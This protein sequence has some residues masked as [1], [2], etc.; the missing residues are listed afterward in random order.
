VI[1]LARCSTPGRQL[2][3]ALA[4]ATLTLLAAGPGAQAADQPD[5]AVDGAANARFAWQAPVGANQVMFERGL[6]GSVLGDTQFL[7]FANQSAQLPK[8]AVAPDGTA[9]FVWERRDS[10][11]AA[12]QARRRFPDGSLGPVHVLAGSNVV[13]GGG[14]RVAVDPAGNATFTW[15][16]INADGDRI[17]QTRRLEANGTLTATQ[18][19]SATGQDASLPGLAAAPGGDVVFVWQR[20]N[21][22]NSIAQTRRR[23]A[24][25][26]FSAVQ[27]LSA[28]GQNAS[29]SRV[30]VDDDGDATFAWLRSDGTNDIVQTRRRTAA[31]VLSGVEDLSAAGQ[32]AA[33][34]AVVVD[35]DDDAAFAWRRSNGSNQVVQSRFRTSDGTL[36]PAQTIS[37]TGQDVL[38]PRV[39][40]DAGGNATFAWTRF[41]GSNFV[42]QTRRRPAGGSFDTTQNL[43][44]AGASALDPRLAVAPGGDA[45]FAWVRS[46]VIQGRRRAAAGTLGPIL[47]VGS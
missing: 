30:A 23:A 12:V 33:Q 13:L 46:G 39:G 19:V 21:G 36:G 1:A 31:G 22:A 43:S 14:T 38:S 34:P 8:V 28:P 45:V 42:A 16:R 29:Q 7:S 40:L 5:V 24:A 44:L 6:A 26:G 10:G 41:N 4:A 11:V 47:D 27:D 37:A 25:G 20:S 35:P 15:V 18:A 32:S 9:T 17:V 3:R 2:L